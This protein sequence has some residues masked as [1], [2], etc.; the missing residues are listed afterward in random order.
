MWNWRTRDVPQSPIWP[1]RNKSCKKYMDGRSSILL[2]RSKKWWVDIPIFDTILGNHYY[3]LFAGTFRVTSSRTLECSL[4]SDGKTRCWKKWWPWFNA[5]Q[6]TDKGMGQG[7]YILLI[8]TNVFFH[9]QGNLQRSK[10]IQDGLEDSKNQVQKIFDH[11]PRAEEIIQRYM[12]KRL[13]KKR[14]K[15]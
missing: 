12:Y 2:R 11:K 5:R 14:E 6:W 1:I 10:V 15:L 7:W 4:G 13:A 9:V 8:T 3:F